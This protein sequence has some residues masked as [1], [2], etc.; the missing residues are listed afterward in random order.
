MLFRSDT[1][2]QAALS[3]MIDSIDTITVYP[4]KLELSFQA[5]KVPGMDMPSLEHKKNIS[6]DLEKNLTWEV[7][8]GDD[9]LYA[10]RKEA[11]VRRI[12]EYIRHNPKVTAKQIAGMEGISLSAANARI[13]K[14]KKQ[15]KIHYEGQGGHGEWII[16]KT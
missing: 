12:I 15:G 5:E 14:L 10:A 7:P 8:L 6:G 3:D 11:E 9:F 16:D 13:R 2:R 1:V 4:E